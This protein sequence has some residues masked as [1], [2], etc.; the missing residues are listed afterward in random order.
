MTLHI[1]TAKDFPSC[2]FSY[3]FLAAP[4]VHICFGESAYAL[5]VAL[6]GFPDIRKKEIIGVF[7]FESGGDP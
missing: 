7:D 3:V 2:T 5:P 1:L 6:H 4:S